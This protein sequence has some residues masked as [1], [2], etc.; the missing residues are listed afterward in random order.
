MKVILYG[1]ASALES[2]ARGEVPPAYTCSFQPEKGG[3]EL[4]GMVKI[5]AL[6][7]QP[8]FASPEALTV[9][10]IRLMRLEQATTNQNY[11]E[12]ISKLSALG[13]DKS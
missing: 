1:S 12:R 6:N 2:L 3:Y 11:E 13:W 4:G 7:L 9:E 5:C 10:A 8:E